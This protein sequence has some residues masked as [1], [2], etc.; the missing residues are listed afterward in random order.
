VRLAAALC[1]GACLAAACAPADPPV[2]RGQGWTLTRAQLAAEYDRIYGPHGYQRARPERRARFLTAAVNKQLLLDE[3]RRAVPQLS[4]RNQRRVRVEAGRQLLED[5]RQILWKA[6]RPD[7]ARLERAGER[8]AREVRAWAIVTAGALRADSCRAALAAGAPFEEVWRRWGRDHPESQQMDLGW[9]DPL[10][11]PPRVMRG[12]FLNDLSPGGVT[13]PIA[14][15]RGIW[16]VRAVEYRP[17]DLAAREG[18]AAR[19]RELLVRMLYRDARMAARD[20]LELAFGYR[21]HPAACLPV[22]RAVRAYLDSV[23]ASHG[24]GEHADP[25]SVR[26][27]HWRLSVEEGARPLAELNGE[28]ITAADFVRGLDEVDVRDWPRRP[29]ENAAVGDV[30]TEMMRRMLTLDARRRGFDARP[31][32]LQAVQR[33]HDDA[34]LDEYHEGVLLPQIAVTASEVDSLLAA[35][36]QRWAVPERV[37]FSAVIFP[38]E[39]GAAAREFLEA[40]RRVDAYGWN[41]LAGGISE[42]VAEAEYIETTDMLDVGRPPEPPSWQPMLEAAAQL[43]VGG[44]TGPVPVP[45]LGGNAVVRLIERLPAAPLAPHAARAVAE[46]EV[47]LLKVDA[48]LER[49]LAAAGRRQRVRTW[50]ERLAPPEAPG[51]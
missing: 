49:I 21:L 47:R 10:A 14:T 28:T 41:D 22:A 6:G 36:P 18:Y 16:I 9:R 31:D 19:A 32:Y 17:F 43:P 34:L 30:G 50:P 29:G 7:S 3:A 13:A 23:S 42:G 26:A 48:E 27:P 33:R 46:R 40:A 45:E 37:E 5:Y 25:W 4:P 20:S 44:I 8:V 38:A 35:D 1:A 11:L 2:A 15:R 12:V 51:R 24:P 39:Q